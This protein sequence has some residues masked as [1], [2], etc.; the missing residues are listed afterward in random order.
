MNFFTNFVKFNAYLSSLSAL[1]LL[2]LSILG[3][4]PVTWPEIWAWFLHGCFTLGMAG[5]AFDSSHKEDVKKREALAREVVQMYDE[6]LQGRVND[7]LNKSAAYEK[8][9][10]GEV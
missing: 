2:W 9:E 6:R 10:G 5:V 3:Y 4:H 8:I 1:A 7:L